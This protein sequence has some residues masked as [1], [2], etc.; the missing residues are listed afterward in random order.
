MEI[1]AHRGWWLQAAEKN[2]KA[3]FERALAAGYGIETDVRDCDGELV[4]SHDMPRR[5]SPEPLMTLA[6]FLDLYASYPGRPTLALNIKADGLHEPTQAALT[7]RSIT[8][9][10]VFDMSVPDTLGWLRREMPVFTR[11]SEF[12]TGSS[13]DARAQGF[14]L[15]AFEA[16]YVRAA[17]I[18]A[19]IKAGKRAAVVSPELHGKPHL[20]AWADWRD[21]LASLTDAQ[22]HNVLLCTDFPGEAG[23]CFAR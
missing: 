16:P 2:S 7:A 19:A 23:A 18:A 17:D 1:L 11:R 8:S 6:Q 15:D 13:L 3:A 14:W 21:V 10:F 20:E 22:R 4:I 12:E 5:A 9:Y